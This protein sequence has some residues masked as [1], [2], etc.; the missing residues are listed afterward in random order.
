M[1][2][3]S[4]DDLP[5]PIMWPWPASDGIDKQTDTVTATWN[6]GFAAGWEARGTADEKVCRERAVGH[7]A[8]AAIE[9]KANTG[10]SA[11]WGDHQDEAECCADDIA[12]LKP[13]TEDIKT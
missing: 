4:V 3:P 13:A 10:W 2:G 5:D 6:T 9:S 11:S 8:Q 7:K 12:A 1:N